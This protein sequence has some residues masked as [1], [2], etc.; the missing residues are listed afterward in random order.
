MV[1][2]TIINPACNGIMADCYKTQTQEKWF[3]ILVAMDIA[4]D[5]V[6]CRSLIFCRPALRLTL[7]VVCTASFSTLASFPKCVVII[8]TIAVTMMLI[9]ITLCSPQVVLCL[10]LFSSVVNVSAMSHPKSGILLAGTAFLPSLVF[11]N[12]SSSYS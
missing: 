6:L 11:L 4:N 9:M 8:L 7:L 5:A 1:Y 10:L 3:V 2:Y 12:C